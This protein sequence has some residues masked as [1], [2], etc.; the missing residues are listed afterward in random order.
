MNNTNSGSGGLSQEE[1]SY[2]IF[3]GP[4]FFI[5]NDINSD[6][7]SFI[8]QYFTT[9]SEG[10]ATSSEEIQL[11]INSTVVSTLCLGILGTTERGHAVFVQS[12]SDNEY[13][14][15]DPSVDLT[16]TVPSYMLKCVLRLSIRLSMPV[17]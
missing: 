5:N 17:F 9:N 6:I 11:C 2:E 1:L 7:I 16:Y 13:T 10:W 15:F 3:Y 8:N 4:K 12:F 14:C